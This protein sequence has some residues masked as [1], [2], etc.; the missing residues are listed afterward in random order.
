MKLVC[1]SGRLDPDMDLAVRQIME[2][3]AEVVMRINSLRA[4]GVDVF[5]S[6]K[7]DANNMLVLT[8]VD[9]HPLGQHTIIVGQ[10]PYVAEYVVEQ[11]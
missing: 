5:V 8:G 9:T 1:V 7:T 6:A 10:T 4:K 3:E 11:E 2:A